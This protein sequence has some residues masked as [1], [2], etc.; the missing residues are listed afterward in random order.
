VIKEGWGKVSD[1]TRV[2][3]KERNMCKTS[4]DVRRI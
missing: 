4:Y 1:F 3:G 2:M